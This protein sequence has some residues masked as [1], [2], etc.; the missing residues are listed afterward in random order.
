MPSRDSAP[1]SPASATVRIGVFPVGIETDGVRAPGA[2]FGAS[3]RFVREVVESLA[4]RSMIIGVD[5]LDYSKGIGAADATRSSDF[6]ANYPRLARRGDLSADHA[7]AA[8]PKSANTPRWSGAISET[9]GRINGRYGE[10]AWTPI[11]YV[12]RAYSRTALAGLYRSVA[13]R[14]W[15]RRCA[16]A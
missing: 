11:R 3:R 13:R 1:S 9:V 4:G 5:R 15:S 6:L 14:R 7:D 10:A 8:A 12:N 16:T 2:P